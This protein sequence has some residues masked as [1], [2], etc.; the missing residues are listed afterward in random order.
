MQPARWEQSLLIKASTALEQHVRSH[1]NPVYD[2]ARLQA[3]HLHCGQ[4]TAQNSRTFFTA[5][6]LIPHAKR[7]AIRT[8]YAFCRVSDDVVD[9]GDG[10][11]CAR[12]AEWRAAI[13]ADEVPVDDL[14]LTAWHDT[15]H[16]YH[17]PV[18]YMEQL[19]DALAQDLTVNRYDTFEQLTDY[20]Y[21]VASTVGL[22]SMH[23]T[24]YDGPI[25]LPYAVKLGVALQLTNILRDVGEDWRNGAALS[26]PR[27]AGRLWHHRGGHC[28]RA[29]GRA[30]AGL[31]ALPDRPRPPAL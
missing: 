11:R 5:T 6:A 20:C 10:D 30:L 2:A 27:G 17:I 23:V 12:L 28:R 21:G 25:A 3:A 7:V 16:R 15:R 8:L 26:A 13:R 24:G 1:F 18:L 29:G 19:L 14:V 9:E 31:H 22:M 4:I